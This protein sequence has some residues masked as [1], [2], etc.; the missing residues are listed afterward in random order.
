MPY[1]QLDTSATFTRDDKTRFAAALA[2]CY[3]E[4]MAMDRRRISVAIREL[5]PDGLWRIIDGQPCP[6]HVLMCDIRRGRD[7]ARRQ[8]LAKAMLMVCQHT[9][10][11]APERINVEFTQHSADEMYHPALGGF[12]PEWSPAEAE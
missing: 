9:L 6:A 3:A 4:T 7:A 1:L 11:L 5:G 10:G 8:T 2:D 12:S